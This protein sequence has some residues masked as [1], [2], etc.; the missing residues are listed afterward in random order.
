MENLML[1]VDPSSG[2]L[3]WQVMIAG[4]VGGLFSIR[5]LLSAT[6]TLKRGL[7]EKLAFLFGPYSVEKD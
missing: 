2:S 3:M 1:Y 6:K 4:V 5:K 7:F